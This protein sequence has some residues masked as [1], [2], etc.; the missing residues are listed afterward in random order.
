M[1]VGKSKKELRTLDA[2]ERLDQQHLT[3][4]IVTAKIK[5][6]LPIC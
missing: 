4:C 1:P 5:D 6:D 2:M 3:H